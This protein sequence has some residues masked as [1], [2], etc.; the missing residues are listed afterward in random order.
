MLSAKA[1]MSSA[2]IL[3]VKEITERIGDPPNKEGNLT[4]SLNLFR[5]GPMLTEPHD[6]TFHKNVTHTAFNWVDIAAR[7][8]C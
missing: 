8:N 4:E 2:V 7:Y 6:T 1:T 5:H 3:D